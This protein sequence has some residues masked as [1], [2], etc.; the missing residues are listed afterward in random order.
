MEGDS[1]DLAKDFNAFNENIESTYVTTL[2]FEF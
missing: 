2:S 1:E